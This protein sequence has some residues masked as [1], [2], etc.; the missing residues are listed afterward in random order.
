MDG[1]QRAQ[2]RRSGFRHEL[3]NRIVERDEPDSVEDSV[4]VLRRDA[5]AATSTMQ[6]DLSDHARD[7]VGPALKFGAEGGGL[8]LRLYE[9]DQRRTVD[10]EQLLNGRGYSRSSR[11]ISRASR[12]LTLPFPTGLGG[13][14]VAKG[15][16]GD[17]S[18]RP[19]DDSLA[20]GSG[21]RGTRRATGSPRSV[22]SSVT[23][24]S[25]IRR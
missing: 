20:S 23:P 16:R 4:D 21:E 9:L 25:T 2:N 1:I 10:V 19:T 18:R 3:T 17:R 24:R 7:A 22:T 14:S 8:V 13:R 11:S 15:A 6:L 5:S 12:K